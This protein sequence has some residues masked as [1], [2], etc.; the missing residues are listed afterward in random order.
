[1]EGVASSVQQISKPYSLISRPAQPNK[2]EKNLEKILAR[3]YTDLYMLTLK[4]GV[5]IHISISFWY[6]WSGNSLVRLREND[7][8][9]RGS[10]WQFESLLCFAD[11]RRNF[12]SGDGHIVL[13]FI[14]RSIFGLINFRFAVTYSILNAPYSSNFPQSLFFFQGEKPGFTLFQKKL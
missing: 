3:Y 5:N 1:M 8:R 2:H 7:T 12:I 11:W 13:L 9:K 4:A 10:I 6:P 14:L